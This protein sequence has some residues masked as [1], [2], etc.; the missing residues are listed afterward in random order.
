MVQLSIQDRGLHHNRLLADNAGRAMTPEAKPRSRTILVSVAIL[1]LILANTFVFYSGAVSQNG[2]GTSNSTISSLESTIVSLRNSNRALQAQLST[3][4]GGPSSSSSSATAAGFSFPWSIPTRIT[5]H[6]AQASP[7]LTTQIEGCLRGALALPPTSAR[8]GYLLPTF[9]LAPYHHFSSSFYAFFVKYKGAAGQI[10]SDL[11]MLSVNVGANWSDPRVNTEKPFYDFLTS[12]AAARC[13]LV[14]GLNLKVTNDVAVDGGT[15]FTNGVRNYDVLILGH[16]EYVTSTEYNQLRLFVA[17]GGRIVDMSGNSFWAQVSYDRITAVET[18]VAG[19]GF[20]FN[21]HVAWRTTYEPFDA[22]SVNWFGSTFAN[23][24]YGIHGA[25][26][27]PFG[28]VGS[29]LANFLSGG[30]AFTDYSYPHDEVNYL[31]NMT[32]TQVIARFYLSVTPK[33]SGSVYAY[34]ALPVDAYVHRYVSG[35]IVCFCVFG[36]S[37]IMRD[38]GAQFFLLFAMSEGFGR[39][40]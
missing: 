31:R 12:P 15:L 18:F 6:P 20:E 11:G 21:G 40:P 33:P 29:A 38:M 3:L 17:T 8:V 26:V 5:S 16:E 24:I 7:A 34:P 36:E 14:L 35:D 9:T 13:G 28:G 4:S 30:R 32:D 10:T 1:V 19:H 2:G 27:N 25:I 22:Q 37:I 23:G 39:M